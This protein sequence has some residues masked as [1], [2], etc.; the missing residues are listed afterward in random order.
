ML[1]FQKFDLFRC[2]LGYRSTTGILVGNRVRKPCAGGCRNKASVVQ[3]AAGVSNLP[4]AS[5]YNGLLARS[6]PMVQTACLCPPS[7]LASLRARSVVE[8]VAIIINLL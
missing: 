1:M 6:A 3:P 2:R 7:P 4:V 5:Q 8:L